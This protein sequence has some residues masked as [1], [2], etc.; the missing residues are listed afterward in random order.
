ML[1]LILDASTSG[2]ASKKE[3]PSKSELNK[4]KRKEQKAAKKAAERE[5]S[6]IPIINQT[7]STIAPEDDPCAAFYGDSPLV[8]SEFMTEKVYVQIK[9]LDNSMVGHDQKVWIRARVGTSRT[10]S[11]GVFLLLRQTVHTVQGVL[12][13][14]SQGK[15]TL[16]PSG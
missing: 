2:G 4:L 12:F 13:Q 6:G 7:S 5:V 1:L 9:N 11:K 16:F 8:R 14:G 10:V 15:F 3:G